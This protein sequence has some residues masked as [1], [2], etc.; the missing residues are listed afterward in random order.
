MRF[1]IKAK[2]ISLCCLFLLVFVPLTLFLLW[3]LGNIVGSFK[4]AVQVSQHTIKEAHLIQ[5]LVVDM[6]T[7]QRGF[8][9]TGQDEFLEPYRNARAA[10]KAVIEDLKMDLQGQFE[11]LNTLEKVE[12]LQLKWVGFAGE[13]EIRLRRLIGETEIN[14]KAINQIIEAGAGKRIMDDIRGV[15]EFMQEDFRKNGK[16]D[17]LILITEIIKAVVDAETGQRGFLLA[18]KDRFLEPYYKGQIVFHDDVQTLKGLLEDETELEGLAKVEKLFAQWISQAAKPEIVARVK[19]ENNPRAMLDLAAVLGKGTGKGIIDELRDVTDQFIGKLETETKAGLSLSEKRATLANL[20]SL[21]VSIAGVVVIVI[22]SVLIARSIIQ[23]VGL[24]LQGTEA[25]ARGDL[26]YK[27]RLKSKDELGALADAFNQ[28]SDRFSVATDQLKEAKMAAEGANQAKSEFL[29]TMSHELRTPLNAIIGFGDLL[30]MP[31]SGELN[32]KQGQYTDHILTGSHHLLELIT[33]ILDLSRIEAGRL[34]L[35]LE[36]FDVVSTLQAIESI[37]KPVADKKRISLALEVEGNGELSP[38][39]IK[40]DP[41]KF[42]QI[43]Y[44]LLSNSVKFTPEGG[45]VTVKVSRGEELE[46]ASEDSRSEASRFFHISVVDT[47]IGIKAEDQERIFEPFTQVD[48]SYSRRHQ[49]TGLGLSLTRKLVELHGGH[50]WVESEGE[51]KGTC[52][53]IELPEVAA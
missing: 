17:E 4:G 43:F 22:L 53:T 37:F 29:A 26:S 20:V 50:L 48:S 45:R 3:N 2:L 35:E 36:E 41:A 51:G 33:E 18:G 16:K 46:E 12:R 24:L 49:G 40:A 21:I 42:K 30:K 7:G 27:V 15:V 8:I 11:H 19:Y 6:E 52:F 39:P 38:S 23:P 13:P 14:L 44:N 47:G 28:M 5:K 34:E 10:F 31:V 25:L 9:I 1:T 32:D